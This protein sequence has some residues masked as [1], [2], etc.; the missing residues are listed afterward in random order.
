MKEVIEETP[1][2]LLTQIFTVA[3]LKTATLFGLNK[4]S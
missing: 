2:W 3:R 1:A 4:P